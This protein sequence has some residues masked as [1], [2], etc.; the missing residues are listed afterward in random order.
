[1]GDCNPDTF[2]FPVTIQGVHLESL[3][4]NK[5]IQ[6]FPNPSNGLL[7]VLSSDG[8]W[9]NEKLEIF[10]SHGKI[11]FA[12]MLRSNQTEIDCRH[13]PTGSYVVVFESAGKT[14][15]FRWSIIQ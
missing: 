8:F 13:L 10:N 1:M 9:P 3:S 11:V 12:T 2:S 14:H 4:P 7:H 5:Q 6:I 15:H